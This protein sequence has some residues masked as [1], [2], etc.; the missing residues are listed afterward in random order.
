M[1]RSEVSVERLRT[2]TCGETLLRLRHMGTGV[3]IQR[4]IGVEPEAH[5][6]QHMF[7]ELA[8]L[9]REFKMRDDESST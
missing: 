6:R 3:S 7:T 8:E 4:V 5:Q 2:G 1:K 9:V